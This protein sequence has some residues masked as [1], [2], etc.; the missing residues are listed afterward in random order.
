MLVADAARTLPVLILV[1]VQAAGHSI[2][3]RDM[4]VVGM[5]LSLGAQ[6]FGPARFA[7]LPELVPKERLTSANGLFFVG[8]QGGALAGSVIGGVAVAS[9]GMVSTLRISAEILMV[10]IISLVSLWFITTRF[11]AQKTAATVE[12]MAKPDWWGGLRV[13]TSSRWLTTLFGATAMLYLAF[14]PLIVL[15]PAWAR[16][17]LGSGADGYGFLDLHSAL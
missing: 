9:L 12:S 16:D 3:Y 1:A 2:T 7:V 10:S 14:A 15:M 6:F 5:A 17:R 13:V 4:I 11:S 8:E